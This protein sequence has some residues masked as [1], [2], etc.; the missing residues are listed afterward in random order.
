[1]KI[2]SNTICPIPLDKRKNHA[3]YGD[4]DIC[5]GASGI[6]LMLCNLGAN[7]G[8]TLRN[9]VLFLVVIAVVVALVYLLYGG[10]KWITSKGEKTE[11]EAARNHIMA[12]VMGLIVV[13]LAIFILTIILT[14]FGISWSQL[15]IP[16]IGSTK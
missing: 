3:Y 6:S 16:T 15:T 5:A 10:I 4:M 2:L 12:A 9:I 7:A 1:M 8:Q 14:A 11:V 13:F